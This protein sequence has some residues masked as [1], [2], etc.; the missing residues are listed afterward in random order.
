MSGSFL[1]L[2]LDLISL[3]LSFSKGPKSFFSF[4]TL[5]KNGTITDCPHEQRMVEKELNDI[6]S[7]HRESG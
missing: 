3:S 2:H 6:V 7:M 5:R 1:F 4:S